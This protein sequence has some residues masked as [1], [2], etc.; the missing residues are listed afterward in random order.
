MVERTHALHRPV[1]ELHCEGPVA[2]VEAL[3]EGAERAVGV[4]VLLEDARGRPRMRRP[5]Q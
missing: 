3:R 2:L 4:G 1:G 5:A